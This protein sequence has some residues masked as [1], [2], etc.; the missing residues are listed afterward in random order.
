MRPKND[1]ECRDEHLI[2]DQDTKGNFKW[3]IDHDSIT[4]AHS[5]DKTLQAK[6]RQL[7]SWKQGGRRFTFDHCFDDNVANADVY[8]DSCQNI[9]LS[10]LQGINGT[11]LMYG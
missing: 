7:S 6:T 8:K 9:V 4:L 1:N 11:I 2:L 10:A 5:L 3:C